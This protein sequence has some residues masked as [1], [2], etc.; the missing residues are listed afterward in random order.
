MAEVYTNTYSIIDIET[1]DSRGDLVDPIGDVSVEVYDYDL[2]NEATD[3]LGSVIEEGVASQTLYGDQPA[4]GRFFY[5]LSPAV[6]SHP[7]NLRLTW[8]FSIDPGEGE[9]RV[10]SQEV[11]VNVPYADLRKLRELKELNEYS[12]Q[13]IMAMERLVSRII[14]SYC[15]QSF[16]FEKNRTKTVMGSGS[17]YLILPDR[18]WELDNV[19]ILDDFERIVRDSQGNVVEIDRSGRS[20]MEYVVVDL[21]NPWRIRNKRSYNFVSLDETRRRDFFRNGNVYA[22]T[23]NWGYPFVPARVT[24]ATT[25]LIKT[26]FYDDSA[27]RD[28]YISSIQAGNWRMTFSATGDATTG[29]A[30]ADIILSSYRNI[31]AA[32]L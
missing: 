13:E 32:V 10:L 30:N 11:F 26:Y 3:S 22:V 1:F 14:D 24:E 19:A 6:T 18:L 12:D 27:Y 5:E 23:G 15:G 16:G 20:L 7:R 2:Y 28:R 8:R 25:I 31:N 21:D 29:S 17:E 9:E 4:T